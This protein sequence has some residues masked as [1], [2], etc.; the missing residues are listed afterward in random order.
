MNPLRSTSFVRMRPP[1]A[2]VLCAHAIFAAAFLL[3]GCSQVVGGDTYQI[4]EATSRTPEDRRAVWQLNTK[5]G[6]I[7]MCWMVE[8]DGEGNSDCGTWTK[9][10]SKSLDPG[11]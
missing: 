9:A 8:G 7:R 3:P 2:S 5:T 4:I 10:N 1:V 11:Q 6:E